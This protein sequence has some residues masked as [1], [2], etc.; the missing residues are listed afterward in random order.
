MCIKVLIMF[1]FISSSFLKNGTRKNMLL[2][3]KDLHYVYSSHCF[4]TLTKVGEVV[5]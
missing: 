2:N 4:I 5:N 3:L 1:D